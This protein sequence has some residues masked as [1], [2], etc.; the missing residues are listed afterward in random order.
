MNLL[1]I[2]SNRLGD[3]VLSMGLLSALAARHPDA[4]ITVVCGPLP[5]PLF[6]HQPGVVRVLPLA[7]RRH[8]LHWFDLWRQ[9]VGGFWHLIVDLRNSLIGLTLPRLRLMRLGRQRSVRHAVEEAASLIGEMVPTPPRL[10]LSPAHREAAAAIVPA[11]R[12]VLALGP[13]A[14]WAGKQWPVER[15]IDLA[16]RL[17]APGAAL[18]GAAI[19]VSAAAHERDI[20]Q[21]VLDA[22]IGREAVDLIGADLPSTA[23]ALARCRLYI[24]NDSGL[25]HMS[26]AVGTPTLGLFGP[27]DDRRYRPWGEQCDFVRAPQ[28]WQALIAAVDSGAV[29]GDRLMDEVTVEMA[30]RAAERLLARTEPS[31]G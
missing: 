3:A 19:L 23:A 12:P 9:T 11:G 24:G 6:A 30:Q 28:D 26:A 10:H 4:R 5:A 20:A 8:G 15:F 16:R 25:M 1:F 27:T 22:F 13:A 31:H 17:T 14:N 2:T 18:E 7:K 29:P 21:P